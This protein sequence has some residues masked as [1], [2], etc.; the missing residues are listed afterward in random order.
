MSKPA[1]SNY[2]GVRL[3]VTQPPDQGAPCIVTL[4]TKQT[5]QPWDQW[6]LLFPALRMPVRDIDSY[7]GI[8]EAVRGVLQA[9]I[10]SELSGR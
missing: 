1:K 3:T 5:H 6:D 10:E 8:L 4:A 9:L 2:A 7:V